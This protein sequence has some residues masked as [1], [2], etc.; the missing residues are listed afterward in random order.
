MNVVPPLS[1]LPSNSHKGPKSLRAFEPVFQN[2][3]LVQWRVFFILLLLKGLQ[4]IE[5]IENKKENLQNLIFSPVIPPLFSS[6]LEPLVEGKGKF[7]E[8]F[9]KVIPLISQCTHPV[10]F[11]SNGES[12]RVRKNEKKEARGHKAEVEDTKRRDSGDSC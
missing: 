8:K 10:L 7:L 3:R 1:S 9:L 5:E 6:G 12:K 2:E 4:R 11:G